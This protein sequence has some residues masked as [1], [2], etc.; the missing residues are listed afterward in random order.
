MNPTD[1]R[2]FA[3][4]NNLL[5]ERMDQEERQNSNPAPPPAVD[6]EPPDR[7]IGD[8]PDDPEPPRQPIRPPVL[9]GAG[10]AVGVLTSV[11]VSRGVVPNLPPGSIFGLPLEYWAYLSLILAK[12]AGGGTMAGLRGLKGLGEGFACSLGVDPVCCVM[13]AW[14]WPS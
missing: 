9:F 1:T 4:R 11:I 5:A 7:Y 8:A 13:S 12:S 2:T 3:P 10:F 6:Y 14:L